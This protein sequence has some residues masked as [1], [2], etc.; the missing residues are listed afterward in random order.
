[1]KPPADALHQRLSGSS[2]AGLEVFTRSASPHRHRLSSAVLTLRNESCPSNCIH[3]DGA[4]SN[5]GVRSQGVLAWGR[6][7]LLPYNRWHM[8]IDFR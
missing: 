5:V 2:D 6:A 4:F 1:M 3:H 7:W 8:L